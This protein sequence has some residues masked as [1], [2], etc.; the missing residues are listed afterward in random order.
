M[1]RAFGSV[2]RRREASSGI[3]MRS[4]AFEMVFR[5]RSNAFGVREAFARRSRGIREA[6]ARRLGISVQTRSHAFKMHSNVFGGV[7]GRSGLEVPNWPAFH[8]FLGFIRYVS[9]IYL[10]L[11]IGLSRFISF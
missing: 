1:S 10:A 9:P 4:E 7:L 6:F 11:S 2:R 5:M 3:L 8:G